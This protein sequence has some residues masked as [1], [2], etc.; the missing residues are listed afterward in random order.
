V[1]WGMSESGP[2]NN[3]KS[4]INAPIWV[5][6]TKCGGTMGS[7]A[8]AP[9]DFAY[10]RD[11]WSY[12]KGA[13]ANGLT[14]YNAWNMV[15]DKGG[16]GIDDTRLWPQNALLVADG[17]NVIATPAY[18][19]YRHFSQYVDPGAKVIGSSSGDV[20]AFKNPD[21]SL[22]AVVYST[23]A[24]N[25]YVLSIG[26]KKLQFNMPVGWATVKVNP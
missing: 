3:I 10:A 4:K 8:P 16:L 25:N 9:N 21:N 12:I 13:I 26:G 17:G 11:T 24:N 23:S 15:L 6:E 2:V 20:V 18:Y 19:V 5:S 14:A 22:V 7:T 1:Q